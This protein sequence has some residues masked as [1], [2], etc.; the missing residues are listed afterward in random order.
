MNSFYEE[1]Y[2]HFDTGNVDQAFTESDCILEGE[3]RIGGQEHFYLETQCTIA[4]PK[5]EDEMEIF[6]ATQDP[7]AT[8]SSI[9]HMLNV[10]INKITV[11][12]KRLGGA[13]GGKETR[14]F[15]ITLPVAFAAYRYIKL[16]FNYIYSIRST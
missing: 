13:F 11:R 12:V 1:S 16:R 2:K 5:E 3:I 10:P 6:S 15:L 8:Q 4:V 14:S 9:A 7:T